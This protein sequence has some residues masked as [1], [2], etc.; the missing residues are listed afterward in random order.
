M[1]RLIREEEP[2]QPSIRISG[3]GEALARISSQR[4]TEPANWRGWCVANWTGS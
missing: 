3:S 1:L 2:L 4:K